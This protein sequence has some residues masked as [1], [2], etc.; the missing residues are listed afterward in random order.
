MYNYTHTC[1]T[2]FADSDAAGVI[3]FTRLLCYVEEAEHA[4]LASLGLPIILSAHDALHWPRVT[5]NAEYLGPVYPLQ[6]ITVK[7]SLEK[8]G[9][10]SLVWGWEILTS[11]SCAARG[12]LKTV[13]CRNE[14][15]VLAPVPIPDVFSEL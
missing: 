6:D 3:H 7:L 2:R 15:G 13:C 8:V 9:G 4:A 1:Q 5:V 14:S 12:S 11:T 10:T